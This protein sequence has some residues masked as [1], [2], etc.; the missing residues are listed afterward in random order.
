MCT[1]IVRLKH[2]NIIAMAGSFLFFGVIFLGRG[3]YR[4][5]ESQ[6]L[7]VLAHER[8]HIRLHHTEL[9]ILALI[10]CFPLLPRIC[11]QQEFSADAGAVKAGCGEALRQL[12]SFY[13]PRTFFYP[14]NRERRDALDAK[15]DEQ[16]RMT[17]VK[18]PLARIGVTD[19]EE[20]ELSC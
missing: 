11:R 3:Y 13:Y 4:L 10:F 14:S 8:E 19:Q 16:T 20:G 18:S 5:S 7:A 15:L 1:L 17:P 2:S 12:L 9:R 6:K